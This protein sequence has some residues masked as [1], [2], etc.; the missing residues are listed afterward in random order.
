MFSL[1]RKVWSM[2]KR[3][4]RAQA[5]RARRRPEVEPLETRTLP[6]NF[7]VPRNDFYWDDP[8]NWQVTG[9]H[10]PLPGPNDDVYISDLGYYN[11]AHLHGGYARSG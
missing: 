8:S 6:S 7:F 5:P 9:Q 4:A 3:A 11:A 10:D 1:M 2:T